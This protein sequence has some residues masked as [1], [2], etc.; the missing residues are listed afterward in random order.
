MATVKKHI[1]KNGQIT[2]YIRC[3]D[4][5][6]NGKQIERSMTWKP[7]ANYSEKQIEKETYSLKN[8]NR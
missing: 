4:G 5:Y 1:A 8:L 7:P 2:Y 3:S 6:C